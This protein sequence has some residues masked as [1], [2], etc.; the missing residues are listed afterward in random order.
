MQG[1]KTK[2][3]ND[4]TLLYVHVRVE[5]RNENKYRVGV[6]FSTIRKNGNLFL[7]VFYFFCGPCPGLLIALGKKVW[8]P[9][10]LFAC[11]P[12]A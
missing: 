1:K 9:N 3:K 2:R 7:I 8:C 10:Y 11:P 4:N 12:E 6:C 5:G